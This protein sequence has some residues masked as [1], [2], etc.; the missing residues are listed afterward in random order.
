[1]RTWMRTGLLGLAALAYG[2]GEES[3]FTATSRTEPELKDAGNKPADAGVS[4]S[5]PTVPADTAVT[6]ATTSSINAG[7]A[8]AGAGDTA[9][10]DTLT[11][12]TGAGADATPADAASPPD[13]ASAPPLGAFPT[14]AVKA[15]RAEFIAR[16]NLHIE[17]PTWRQGEI[18]FAADG[19]GGG[20]MRVD[21]AGKLSRYFPSMRPVGSYL[22]ADGSILW[23]DHVQ[24]LMQM[25]RDGK[26]AALTP[27]F[28]GKPIEFA[29]DLSLDAAGNVYTSARHTGAVYRVSPTGEVIRV[30]SG[31]ELPNGV[32]V[33]PTSKYLYIGV[34]GSILRLALPASGTG[35]GRPERFAGA[36]QPDGMAVDAWGNLWVADYRGG[37]SVIAPDGKTLT[38]VDTGGGG[39]INL[40]FG[41]KDLDTVYVAVDFRGIAKI[42]PVPGLRGFL[43]PGAAQYAVKKTLPVTPAN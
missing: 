41:G 22:L 34:P 39:P 35:Y 10:A 28:E 2:C 16:I 21:T 6:D 1:M 9:A 15:A 7:A 36:N 31:L 42:G 40:T 26:L 23:G 38:S 11:N 32:E 33:D 43:Q 12:E 5:G 8:D 19:A 3:T 29:N 14:A 18:F 20:L 30:A 4:D 13:T 24:V 27:E 17:G 37:V 25:S